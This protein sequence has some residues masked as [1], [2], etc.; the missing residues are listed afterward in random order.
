MGTQPCFVCRGS[1]DRNL[2]FSGTY[3]GQNGERWLRFVVSHT[4]LERSEGWGTQRSVSVLA[5]Q[6]VT[7][8]ADRTGVTN[9]SKVNC[10]AASLSDI[11]HPTG[12]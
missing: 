5:F 12:V 6:R 3:L 10:L 8:S 11:L 4:S 7:N 9:W 2:T 1:P